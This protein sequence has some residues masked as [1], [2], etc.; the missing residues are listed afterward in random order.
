MTTRPLRG[1]F[2]FPLFYS[3]IAI[4]YCFT[5]VFTMACLNLRMAWRKLSPNPETGKH[6]LTF[7]PS[8][9]DPS[10]GVFIPCRKCEGCFA[11]EAMYWAIRVYHEASQH[12]R[13]CF[14]TLTY[15]NDHLPPS[16]EQPVFSKFI[17]KLRD[18]DVKLRYFACGEYGERT[19]RPHY[20]AII[21]GQDFLGGAIRINEQLYT[22]PYLDKMWGMGQVTIGQFSMESACYVAGYVH[23][24]IGDPDTFRVMSRRPG[25]GHSWFSKYHEDIA[26]RGLVTIDGKELPFPPYYVNITSVEFDAE[27][28]KTL[29]R[30]RLDSLSVDDQLK[31][32]RGMKNKV[33]NNAARR[34]LKG[35]SI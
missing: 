32:L 33:L 20:H 19:R 27:K 12:E 13:N 24:K 2:H 31:R 7:S 23:K 3:G 17:R 18:A 6:S 35:G 16:L 8:M 29:R 30:Q 14:V 11:Q 34:S 25:I 15:D 10:T 28:L 9:G 4:P 1:S 21:F 26:K 22:N 5:Q